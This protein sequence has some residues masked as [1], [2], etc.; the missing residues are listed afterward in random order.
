MV[1]FQFFEGYLSLITLEL[2]VS[3]KKL[4]TMD[5]SYHGGRGFNSVHELMRA[6]V[7]RAIE[8]YNS[9]SDLREE[10]VSYFEEDE[11]DHI[12]SFRFICRHLGMDPEKTKW[13]I[14]NAT[15]RISTRRRA[16]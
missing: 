8:D 10:A 16:A 7:L 4:P 13:A 15:H 12:F 2:F 1:L 9:S 6:I 11:E 5:M 3:N 14:F